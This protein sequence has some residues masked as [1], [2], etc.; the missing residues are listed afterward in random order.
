MGRR[1][2]PP[3]T[4]NRKLLF[5]ALAKAFFQDQGTSLS[6]SPRS[7]LLPV[8]CLFVDRIW[9][10]TI[11]SAYPCQLESVLREAFRRLVQKLKLS[12]ATDIFPFATKLI[13][14]LN[15]GLVCSDLSDD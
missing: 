12:V 6:V 7:L 4:V 11:P 3:V 13:P 1:Q 9:P 15:A 8:A 2:A 14:F 10:I 5:L